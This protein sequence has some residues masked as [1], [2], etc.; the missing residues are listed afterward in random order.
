[1]V[2][3]ESNIKWPRLGLWAIILLAGLLAACGGNAQPAI[4]VIQPTATP[5]ET[6]VPTQP[7]TPDVALNPA[8]VDPEPIVATPT[9]PP[10][11][12]TTP[13]PSPTIPLAPTRDLP[14]ATLTATHLP[15]QAGLSVE[16]F[17]TDTEVVKP[18]DN[19]TLFWGLRGAQTAQIYRLN[20]ENER[21]WRWDVN[22]SGKITVATRTDE[23]DIARFALVGSANGVEVEQLLLIPM[24]CPE[25]WF[26]EPPPDSCPGAPSQLSVQAEQT[27]ER[28][29]MVWVAGQDR[30]Y[31]VFE[32]GLIPTWA[33]YPDNFVE[34][35]LELDETLVAPPGLQQPVRGFGLV[36]R[37]NPRV[38]DRLGWATTPEISFEG[39][40]QATSVEL[41]VAT[42]Y[43]RTRDG[44]ILALDALNDEW[45]VLPAVVTEYDPFAEGNSEQ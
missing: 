39:M 8:E 4:V 28:G 17:T 12:T 6:P 9:M 7:L 33:Q 35:D 10:P 30:I 38:Q 27:F 14:P 34:G 11:A 25:I 5:T 44:G 41:S 1:M 16:Y 13:G 21:I 26:F 15:T 42:L 31:V 2:R 24:E 18:G 37:S 20:A 32:D 3:S 22:T 23:R 36:W 29:R 40:F 45:T 19:V 43:L